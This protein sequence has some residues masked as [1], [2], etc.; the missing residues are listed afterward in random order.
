MKG[1]G[2]ILSRNAGMLGILAVLA[3]VLIG[4]LPAAHAGQDGHDKAV[5]LLK[6]SETLLEEG[7]IDKAIETVKNAVAAD[8]ENPE[9][10]D[11]LGYMLLQKGLPDDAITAFTSALKIQPTFRTA[12]TGIGLAFLK[13]GDL[14]AAED[15]L[16]AALSLNPYPSMAHYGLGLVYEKMNDYDKAIAQFKEG[17]RTFKSGRK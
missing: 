10:Y 13:K 15:K 16:T 2:G 3:F 9:P 5:T 12:R 11:R 8:P 6:E 4:Y 1:K 14:K 7:H 17:I